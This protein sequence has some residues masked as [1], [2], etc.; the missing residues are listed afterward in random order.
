MGLAT[1]KHLR[2]IEVS[3][4]TY[5]RLQRRAV[6]FEDTPDA[7]IS[8]LLD[9][10]AA[11]EDVR[12]GSEAND[13]A[14]KQ[15]GPWGGEAFQVDIA[16]EDPFDPPSLKHTKVL[17]AEVDGGEVVRANWTV[18]RQTVVAIALGDGGYDLRRLLQFCPMNAITG[19]KDNEGYTHYEDLGVSIQGQDANHAW[20]A[21]AATARAVG[22]PVKVWFQWR[23][24][25]DATHPGKWGLVAIGQED[26]A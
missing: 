24:K 6:P 2:T 14:G 11:N 9:E 23:A 26:G 20:Q 10:S 21:A 7:V 5:D 1:T 22:V 25:P 13:D 17:R 8:R 19:V 12:V 15:E 18:V 16:V 4:H 3:L